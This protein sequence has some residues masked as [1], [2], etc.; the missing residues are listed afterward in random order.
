MESRYAAEYCIRNGS[1]A[2]AVAAINAAFCDL[3]M[4]NRY[5]GTT[6]RL[7]AV[8]GARS[9]AWTWPM[10]DPR[11]D[12]AAPVRIMPS[13]G[14]PGLILVK[15]V[16][17]RDAMDSMYWMPN[18]VYSSTSYIVA[19]GAPKPGFIQKVKRIVKATATRS[20]NRKVCFWSPVTENLVSI[21]TIKCHKND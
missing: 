18:D 20:V 12:A 3:F 2:W 13:G 14:T 17:L 11:R 4:S 16:K 6:V 1:R 19:C 9:P 5:I 8:I 7:E 21:T 10:C 15:A